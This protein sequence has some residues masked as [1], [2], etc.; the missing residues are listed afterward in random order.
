MIHIGIILTY[1]SIYLSIFHE[2]PLEN[3]I[4]VFSHVILSQ[5]IIYFY[6]ASN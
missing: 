2:S 6:C 5:A 1:K 4:T 3:A